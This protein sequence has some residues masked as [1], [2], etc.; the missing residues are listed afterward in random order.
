LK[1]NRL[2]MWIYII[3]IIVLSLPI[4][5]KESKADVVMIHRKG[6]GNFLPEE[7]VS[8]IMTN[9]NVIFN[10]DAVYYRRKININFNGNYTI[11]NPNEAKNATLVASFST[12][13]KNLESS[14][15]IKIENTPISYGFLEYNFTDSPWEDYLDWGYMGNRKFIIINVT[16]PE[17]DSIIIEYSFNAYIDIYESIDGLQIFYDVGTSRAW[18]GTITERVEFKVYGKHPDSY[19]K[20][21]EDQFEYNC[22]ISDIEDGQSYLWEWENEVINVDSVYIS[23]SYYNPWGRLLPFILFPS[24][25]A[26]LIISV[27]LIRRRANRRARVELRD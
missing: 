12:D 5:I 23:F 3:L 6:L 2:V 16:L 19:S 8:L 9:A 26:A 4:N 24:L 14:S 17:N 22:T 7:N 18:N 21:R 27:I 25:A 13:F 10:I 15:V 20:Y 11:Y 1:K